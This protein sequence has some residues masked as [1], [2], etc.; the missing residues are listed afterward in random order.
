[1]TEQLTSKVEAGG[2]SHLDLRVRVPAEIVGKTYTRVLQN[3]RSRVQVAGYRVGKAPLSA[4]RRRVGNYLNQLVAAQLVK[5][6]ADKAARA[7]GLPPIGREPEAHTDGEAVEGQAFEFRVR[8]SGIRAKVTKLDPSYKKLELIMPPLRGDFDIMADKRLHLFLYQHAESRVRD[9]AERVEEGDRVTF[10]CTVVDDNQPQPE[11]FRNGQAQTRIIGVEDKLPGEIE[12]SLQSMSCGDTRRSSRIIKHKDNWGNHHLEGQKVTFDLKV[13]RIEQL[14]LPELNDALVQQKTG[15]VP[16]VEAL[17]SKL[18]QELVDEES[19]ARSRWLE[20]QVEDKLMVKSEVEIPQL[21]LDHVADSVYR[22]HKLESETEEH[23]QSVRQKCLEQAQEVISITA[24][25]AEVARRENIVVRSEENGMLSGQYHDLRRA[26]AKHFISNAKIRQ[27]ADLDAG[28]DIDNEAIDYTLDEDTKHLY[29]L[30]DKLRERS[31]LKKL[32]DYKGISIKNPTMDS[33]DEV[34]EQQLETLRH[35]YASYRLSDAPF[36]L[37][38]SQSI[39]VTRFVTIDNEP[40]PSMSLLRSS[41]SLPR[42]DVELPPHFQVFVGMRAGENKKVL[43][44]E[45]FPDAAEKGLKVEITA[46]LHE[47]HE[48][49]LPTLDDQF[50]QEFLDVEN[51]AAL[52]AKITQEVEQSHKQE[53]QN[54]LGRLILDKLTEESEFQMDTKTL[55]ESVALLLNSASLRKNF[56][57]KEESDKEV[58]AT[59][60]RDILTKA[61]QRYLIT[62]EIARRENIT[63]DDDSEHENERML[64]KVEKLLRKEAKIVDD[65][66]DKARGS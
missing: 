17:R 25:L 59:R 6:N 13:H 45:L 58:E 12:R 42:Q 7:Q 3:M 55:E 30:Q 47:V 2:F 16:S 37:G 24:V 14:L 43:C 64:A 1:M 60:I 31:E 46:L 4:V 27:E 32:A 9:D 44:P 8:L 63:Y 50:A 28:E 22:S 57:V 35:E 48:L 65:H 41:L 21:L 40:V 18:R 20:G 51:L 38:L 66:D 19:E 23:Q 54:L 39:V 52:R 26:V 56:R 36:T 53:Q 15:D 5:D 11:E 49:E 33:C 34:I 10:S 62:A 29:S 61:A